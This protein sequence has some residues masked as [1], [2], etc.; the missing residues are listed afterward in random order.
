MCG[1]ILKTHYIVSVICAEGCESR[2]RIEVEGAVVGKLVEGGAIVPIDPHKVIAS[3]RDSQV[4]IVSTQK[5]DSPVLRTD[6]VGDS[7]KVS[8]VGA[9]IVIDVGVV[10][11][12]GESHIQIINDAEIND[13]P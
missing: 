9:I 8:E 3:A 1:V 6:K 10:S 13:V 11:V 7:L 5:R 12:D 4:L 2:I